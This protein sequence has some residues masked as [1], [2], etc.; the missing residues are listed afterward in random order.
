MLKFLL[1]AL[2]SWGFVLPSVAEDIGIEDI[3]AE[4]FEP[5][6]AE[7]I[8]LVAFKDASINRIQSGSSE[9]RQ[10]GTYQS[11][12]WSEQLGNAI[13]EQ[14]HLRKLTEWPMTEVD[15]HCVVFQ[16]PQQLSV[17]EVISTLE[18]DVRIDIVQTLNTFTTRA[19][20]IDDPYQ[21]LQ[22]NL[23][24]MEIDQIHAKATGKD[25]NITMIDTGVD[26]QHPDLDGQIQRNENFAESFSSSFAQDQ[27]GTAIAGIIVAKKANGA[28]IVGIAPDAK[29]TALKACWP[30][31]PG[32]MEAVCNSYTLALAVNNAI[33]NGAKI[34]NMSLTGPYDP[35]LALL[36][37]KAIAKGIIVVASNTGS[38]LANENFPAMLQHV[39]AVQSLKQ[40][41]AAS[42][43][44]MQIIQAP[45]E[46][47]LT[48][49]PYSTY[50][51]ISGSSMAAAE[52]SG[53]IALLL[54][55]NPALHAEEIKAILLKSNLSAADG[56]SA[57]TAVLSVC[58]LS[59][60]AVNA[61]SFVVH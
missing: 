43:K 13:A 38:G 45:G 55:I 40:S 48:T 39:I 14:Y 16:V 28:G 23:Q 35:L 22:T 61:L 57:K 51:F 20:P 47:I 19:L 50:D 24:R 46:H 60:C 8:L 6:N 59:D 9:Y 32:S 42:N 25:V 56:V 7:H 58:A 53:V 11:T 52:I 15:A 41:S 10:R 17:P 44:A 18:Q 2:L 54:E 27:H 30:K 4:L 3:P 33:K 1:I 36:L 34:L 37:N 21:K 31:H 49:L 5:K 29:L 12:A 26:L